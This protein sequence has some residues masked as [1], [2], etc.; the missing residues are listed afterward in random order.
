MSDDAIA[1]SIQDAL[2][3]RFGETIP[4]DPSTPGLAALETIVLAGSA[5]GRLK[6][7]RHIATP[8]LTPLANLIAGLGQVAGLDL[9]KI[10]NSTGVV[11]L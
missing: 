2:L 6:G 10:E 7:G 3:E 1:K 4:V 8:N 5:S 9:G 11:E